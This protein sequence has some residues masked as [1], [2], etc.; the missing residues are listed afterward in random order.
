MK[1]FQ[2][3]QGSTGMQKYLMKQAKAAE[4]KLDKQRREEEVFKS[5]KNWKPGFTLPEMPHISQAPVKGQRASE[6]GV[7]ALS[8]PVFPGAPAGSKR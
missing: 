8:K 3:G 5:G 6:S 2:V 4:Q 7:K 1:H